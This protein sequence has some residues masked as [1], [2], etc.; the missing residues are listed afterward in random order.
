MLKK[1]KIFLVIP[2][3][4]TFQSCLLVNFIQMTTVQKNTPAL[5]PDGYLKYY[6]DSYSEFEKYSRVETFSNRAYFYYNLSSCENEVVVKAS[7]AYF[8]NG[9]NADSVDYT[10]NYAQVKVEKDE[11][12]C[13]EAII[14]KTFSNVKVLMNNAQR[15]NNGNTYIYYTYSKDDEGNSVKTFD[16]EYSSFYDFSRENLL[17]VYFVISASSADIGDS[18][19]FEEKIQT[20]LENLSDAKIGLDAK[21]IVVSSEKTSDLSAI[22]VQDLQYTDFCEKAEKVYYYDIAEKKSLESLADCLEK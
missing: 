14:K 21:I 15:Y 19:A 17:D 2:L 11:S 7:W 18:D 12:A 9:V 20:M 10:T 13:Y 22:T 6:I 4:L 16:P 1:L 5:D 3:L 8:S